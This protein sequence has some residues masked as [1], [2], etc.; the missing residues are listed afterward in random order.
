MVIQQKGRKV[1][2]M[3]KNKIDG[4]KDNLMERGQWKKRRLFGQ[5]F[6][7]A[8]RDNGSAKFAIV[9]INRNTRTSTKCRILKNW[10]PSDKQ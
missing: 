6:C 5:V 7:I 4:E 2:I 1:L 10:T 3:L 8:N 9:Y